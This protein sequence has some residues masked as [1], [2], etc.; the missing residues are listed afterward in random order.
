MKSVD[1]PQFRIAIK[2]GYR[3]SPE[4]TLGLGNCFTAS[5]KPKKHSG[6]KHESALRYNR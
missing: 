4:V 6:R 2:N 5:G 3:L 1:F